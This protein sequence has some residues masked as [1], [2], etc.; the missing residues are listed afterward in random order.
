MVK[1]NQNLLDAVIVNA[2]NRLVRNR[3]IIEEL[4]D[5]NFST[6][7][8]IPDMLRLIGEIQNQMGAKDTELFNGVLSSREQLGLIGSI[9]LYIF[10][11]NIP[12]SLVDTDGRGFWGGTVLGIVGGGVAAIGFAVSSPAL[13]VAGGIAG[14]VGAV[15]AVN[16][17]VNTMDDMQENLERQIEERTTI[18]C[19]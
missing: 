5:V 2:F 19:L 4:F 10:V 6:V 11:R 17:L 18:G 14:V 7:T 15:I 8:D 16:D 9:D 12:T 1:A 13:I 3:S